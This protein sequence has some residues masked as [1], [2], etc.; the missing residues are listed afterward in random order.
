MSLPAAGAP[1]SRRNLVKSNGSCFIRAASCVA[2]RGNMCVLP[3]TICILH[4]AWPTRSAHQEYMAMTQEQK[5]KV[6]LESSICRGLRLIVVCLEFWR[7][8]HAA[9]HDQQYCQRRMFDCNL[10]WRQGRLP[11][12]LHA[13]FHRLPKWAYS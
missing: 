9:V 2:A 5:E 8:S 11:L 13:V 1:H 4:P 10:V 6:L 7:A 12:L 3:T